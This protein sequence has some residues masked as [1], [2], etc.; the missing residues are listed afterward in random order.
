VFQPDALEALAAQGTDHLGL[1]LFA[2]LQTPPI[3]SAE[4]HGWSAVAA[5]N[6]I[7]LA[8]ASATAID[9]RLL[10]GNA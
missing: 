6:F 7:R 4:G 1:E 5:A 9:T 3:C 8:N 10:A 2:L